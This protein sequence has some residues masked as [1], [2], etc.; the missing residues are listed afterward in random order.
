MVQCASKCASLNPPPPR[1]R[2]LLKTSTCRCSLL[3]RV[4]FG[5]HGA[6]SAFSLLPALQP[7]PKVLSGSSSMSGWT[8]FRVRAWLI[9]ISCIFASV[10]I[11]PGCL[12]ARSDLAGC[13]ALCAFVSGD[14]PDL[15]GQ[16]EEQVSSKNTFLFL[17]FISFALSAAGPTSSCFECGP[18][19]QSRHVERRHALSRPFCC[20]V[21]YRQTIAPVL[22]G[23]FYVYLSSKIIGN[24]SIYYASMHSSQHCC[25]MP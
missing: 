19:V 17:S 23:R 25:S 7:K 10:F 21:Q 9:A 12:T 22:N 14:V 3:L 13:P 11:I 16:S 1:R 2:L 20:S 24:N 8:P 18:L 6:C 5:R 15:E 4:S